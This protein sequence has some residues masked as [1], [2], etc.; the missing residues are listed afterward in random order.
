MARNACSMMPRASGSPLSSA[1]VNALACSSVMCGGNGG[2]SGSTIASITTGRSRLSAASHAAPT[3]AGF[4]T[5]T[6]VE[7]ERSA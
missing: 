1:E 4:S 6:P 7:P 2:T 3:P 5:R